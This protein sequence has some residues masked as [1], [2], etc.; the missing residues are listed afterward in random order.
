MTLEEQKVAEAKVAADKA[1]AYRGAVEQKA[2]VD[3]S[4]KVEV[5]I[6]GDPKG[7]LFTITGENLGSQGALTVAGQTI[8]TTSWDNRRIKGVMPAGLKGDVELKGAFGVRHGKWP[9]VR[10]VVTKTTTVTVETK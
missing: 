2:A 9:H 7:G 8:K 1:A 4:N 10:P 6:E 5:V 3:E